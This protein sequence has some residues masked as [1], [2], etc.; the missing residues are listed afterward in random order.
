M[1]MLA[2]TFHV[3][4][5]DGYGAGKSP[6]WRAQRPLRL[7][8][9]VALLEPVFAR[10]DP[11]V[12]VGHSYGAAVA[13]IAALVQPERVRALALYEPTL[14]ALVDA[15]TPAPNDADG[16][17]LTVA[18]AATAIDAG[19]LHT[20]AE[21]FIDFWM[22]NGAW[23]RTPESR[24][25]PIADS[26]ANIRA[27]GKALFDEPTPLAAFSALNIPVLYM[28][29]ANSPASSH[30]VARLLT[31]VL[32]HVEVVEFAGVGH[33]GPITHP[34]LINDAIAGF[35]QPLLHPLQPA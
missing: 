18:D 23:A 15:D 17:R 10:A 3:L 31:P 24:K 14:F 2:P 11:F 30:A 34:D 35:L 32:P 8:D 16:I 12:L 21:R 22:G 5:A 26:V 20:A 7:R 28:L 25:E 9:E 27:W 29:G 19:D 4:A 33:M 13:L 6:A 1:E